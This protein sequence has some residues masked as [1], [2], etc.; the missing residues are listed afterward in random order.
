MICL[1]VIYPTSSGSQF[2]RKYYLKKHMPFVGGLCK[3][4]GFKR[5]EVSEGRPGMD[6]SKAAY[7]CMANLYFESADELRKAFA[8]HG[9][10]IMADIPKYTNVEPTTYVGE[11]QG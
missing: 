11:I 9:A 3:P 8:K 1:T 5:A 7:H 6:G 10:E 2:D 4:F